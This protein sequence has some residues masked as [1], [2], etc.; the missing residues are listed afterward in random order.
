LLKDLK[1]ILI[2]QSCLR[3]W[4]TKWNNDPP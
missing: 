1:T 2:L 4:W 3:L